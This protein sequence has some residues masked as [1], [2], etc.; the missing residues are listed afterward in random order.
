MQVMS[1]VL[2]LDLPWVEESSRPIEGLAVRRGRVPSLTYDDGIV[3][4]V[5]VVDPG[6]FASAAEVIDEVNASGGPGRVVLV[7]GV[8]PLSWRA[9]LREAEVSFVDV[10]GVAEIDWPR[11]QGSARRFGQSVMRQR[12]SLPLQQGHGLIAQELLLQ[13]L[14]G[15]WPS[16]GELAS[17][18]GVSVPTAS[19]AVSQFAAHGL[20]TKHRKGHRVA[21]EIVDRVAV[22][23]RLAE[24][25]AW[26]GDVT[27]SGYLWGRTMFDVAARLSAAA[28]RSDVGIAV[29][30]RVGA[31][32]TGV[33]GTASPN[34]VRAW[35]VTG[36]R[37]LGDIAE[38][39][40]LEPA[41]GEAA[42]VVLSN[43]RWR[44]GVD[45]RRREQFDDLSAW[46]AHPLRIWCDLHDEQRGT[47]YAAQMWSVVTHGR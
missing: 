14:D 6:A 20:V 47:E 23:E 25:T 8:I 34:E 10:S 36:G 17:G 42:N 32:Y 2:T 19:K 5:R 31:A 4:E 41:S 24:R 40:R 26:P 11:I 7:A 1:A 37:S 16:I 44:L 27:L 43:E 21:V 29:S 12:S 30:G 3:L 13:S 39:L 15:S 46:V 18:S 22:A 33:L 9:A 38:V 35:V 28:D 45:R